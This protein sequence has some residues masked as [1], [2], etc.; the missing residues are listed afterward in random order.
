[1]IE[2]RFQEYVKVQGGADNILYFG[3][4]ISSEIVGN[5]LKK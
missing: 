5:R 3:A 1:M 2:K 4:K